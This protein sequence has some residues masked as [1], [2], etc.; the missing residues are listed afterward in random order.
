MTTSAS[1]IVARTD[2]ARKTR[3]PSLTRSCLDTGGISSRIVRW[4]SAV[5]ALGSCVTSFLVRFARRTGARPARRSSST[6]VSA[7]RSSSKSTSR[8]RPWGRRCAAKRSSRGPP[9]FPRDRRNSS[10][11]R[12]VRAPA[13]AS[14]L[15][16]RATRICTRHPKSPPPLPIFRFRFSRAS[17]AQSS[18][19]QPSSTNSNSQRCRTDACESSASRRRRRLCGS[20]QTRRAS[21]STSS[22]PRRPFDRPATSCAAFLPMSALLIRR[23]R[24]ARSASDSRSQASQRSTLAA[25]SDV[26]TRAHSLHRRTARSFGCLATCASSGPRQS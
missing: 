10:R 12:S 9:R 22:R 20:V 25:G 14:P 16:S 3:L 1:A 19:L 21:A 4:N 18:H 26:S 8:P 2:V 23:S 24:N 7:S 13:A 17:P 5:F 11:D 15:R 6:K